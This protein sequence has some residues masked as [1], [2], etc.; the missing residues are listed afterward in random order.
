M[1]KMKELIKNYFHEY[2]VLV[3]G[4]REYNNYSKVCEVL[5]EVFKK[6]DK[7]FVLVNGKARGADQLSTLWAGTKG[8][9]VTLREYP[10]NWK[11][12]GPSAGP[13]RNQQML[14]SEDV[15]LVIAFPGGV[16]TADMANRALKAKVEVVF[17]NE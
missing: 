2:T 3:T 16:G 6:A 5:N 9:L 4:G 1:N 15:D 8:S 7:P 10:A 17:I 14:D 11:R 12:Y 13:I